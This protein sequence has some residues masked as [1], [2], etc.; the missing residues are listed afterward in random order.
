MKGKHKSKDSLL[1]MDV[2]EIWREILNGLN[3]FVILNE[4]SLLIRGVTISF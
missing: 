3:W 1:K 4:G 2:K